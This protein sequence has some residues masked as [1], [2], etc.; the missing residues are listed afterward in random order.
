L[1]LPI[2]HDVVVVTTHDI[3]RH[4]QCYGVKSVA[5]PNLDS[6]ASSGIRFELAFATAPQCSPSRASLATGRYP[7]NH[8][9]MGLAHRGFDWELRPDVP[10]AAAIFAGVGFDT[11]LFGGQH[12]SLHP[13]RLGFGHVHPTGREHG[14][15]TGKIIGASVEE[16]LSSDL[17]SRRLYLEIN[18]EDTHR[19]YPR[20][21]VDGLRAEVD[22]P[23]YLPAGPEARAELG[24]LQAAI[25]EMDG[26]L[27]SVLAALENAKRADR[28]LVVFTTDHGLA[29]PRAKCTLYDPGLEVALMMRWPDGGIDSGVVLSE[30]VSNIDVLPTLL[31]CAGIALPAGVQGRSLMPLMRGDANEPREAIFA[32]KTFHSYYDPMRCVRTRRHKYIRNFETGFAVEVPGDIQQGPIFRAYPSRYST[33]RPSVVELYDLEA[34]PLEEHN[35]AGSSSIKAIEEGLSAELWR[36]MRETH[37][38]LLNGPIASPRYREAMQP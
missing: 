32:E 34:D 38:P 35:L 27:G 15:M 19:P 23:A 30:L 17:G 11:H 21:D 29:M 22:I 16:L 1:N 14:N 2:A 13:E 31:D 3:G 5:S 7:H 33:D 10:H 20:V 24:A 6:L 12:V 18:F 36:W 26:A 28:A 9:V 25:R 8:G 37:D 4:L